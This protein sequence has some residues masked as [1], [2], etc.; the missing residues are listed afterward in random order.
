MNRARD[1]TAAL[2]TR[3]A[4]AI[5]SMTMDVTIA[6]TF[7][8][9]IDSVRLREAKGTCSANHGTSQTA[10]TIAAFRTPRGNCAASTPAATAA[11]AMP[12]AMVSALVDPPAVSAAE[13]GEPS[14]RGRAHAHPA[15]DERSDSLGECWPE[16]LLSFCPPQQ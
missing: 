13:A 6:I 3:N 2:S 7:S 11:A 12:A 4:A 10:A 15:L 1:A 14:S 16:Q 5:G 8:A 9:A